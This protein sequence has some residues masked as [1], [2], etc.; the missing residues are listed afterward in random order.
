MRPAALG[1]AIIALAVGCLLGWT[2]NRA[3]A[4]HGD[5]RTTHSRIR[6]YR[7]TRLRNGLYA[8]GLAIVLILLVRTLSG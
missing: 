3:H 7:R 5:I 8:I 6:G 4:A 2:A 1:I